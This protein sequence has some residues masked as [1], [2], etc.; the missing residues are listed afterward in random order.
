M[1]VIIRR[2]PLTVILDGKM[3]NPSGNAPRNLDNRCFLRSVVL[4]R[5]DNKI[6]KQLL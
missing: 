2:D 6:L 1:I 3:P 4:K 5:I